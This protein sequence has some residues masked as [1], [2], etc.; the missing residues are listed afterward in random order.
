MVEVSW[1][2]SNHYN[3]EVLQGAITVLLG[4]LSWSMLALIF[5]VLGSFF[6]SLVNSEAFKPKQPLWATLCH[7]FLTLG[8]LI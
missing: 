5:N 2:A 8:D 3:L 6:S 7:S 4:E 1:I